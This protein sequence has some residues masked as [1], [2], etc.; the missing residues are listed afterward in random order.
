MEIGRRFWIKDARAGKDQ[1]DPRYRCKG[2]V[3]RGTH[4]ARAVWISP[5]Q[6][7]VFSEHLTST[8]PTIQTGLNGPMSKLRPKLSSKISECSAVT[9]QECGEGNI[10]RI[11]HP[12]QNQR[13]FNVVTRKTHD[14]DGGVLASWEFVI[15][16]EFDCPGFYHRL[17]RVYQQIQER[18]DSVQLVVRNCSDGLFTHGALVS[19]PRGLVVVWV[20][21]KTCHRS[22]KGEGFDLEV[23][24]GGLDGRFVEGDVRIVLL[25]DVKVLH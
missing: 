22:K 5:Y 9:R 15:P 16:N 13:V 18:I 20:R 12:I 24:R 21:N 11:T 3:K 19:V 17:L 8:V 4:Y 23:G 25:V 14:R 7:C 1:S 10:I 6:R 2:E